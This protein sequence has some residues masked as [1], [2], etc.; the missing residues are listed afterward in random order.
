MKTTLL[1]LAFFMYAPW[2]VASA[3]QLRASC[4]YAKG[5]HLFKGS[6]TIALERNGPKVVVR[7]G[8]R[9]ADDYWTYKVAFEATDLGWFR[10]IRA[11]EV[12]GKMDVL[13]GGELVYLVDNGQARIEVTSLNASN[14]LAASSTMLCR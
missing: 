7:S 6:Q 2:Q 11:G 5:E 3:Q 12:E 10:A 14:G 4:T 1:L 8:A 9:P 13:Q